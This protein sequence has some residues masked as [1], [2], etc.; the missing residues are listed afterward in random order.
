MP[1]CEEIDIGPNPVTFDP[2]DVGEVYETLSL[3]E[4]IF[5]LCGWR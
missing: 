5:E 1:N 3:W 2:H 4:W